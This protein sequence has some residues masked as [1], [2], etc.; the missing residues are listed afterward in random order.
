MILMLL[1]AKIINIQNHCNILL[2]HTITY[3]YLKI[4]HILNN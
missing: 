3:S 1:F 2:N 4:Q